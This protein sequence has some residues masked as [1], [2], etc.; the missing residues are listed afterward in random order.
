MVGIIT[1]LTAHTA[2][3]TFIIDDSIHVSA[4]VQDSGEQGI[5]VGAWQESKRLLMREVDKNA[6]IAQGQ[7][8]VTG[9]LTNGVVPNLPIG[10]VYSVKKDAISDTQEI[11]LDPVR[12][13]RQTPHRQHRAREEAAMM[14]LPDARLT[15][16]LA[17]AKGAYRATQ[18]LGRSGGTAVPGLVGERVDPRLIG[19]L[20]ARL[21]EGA[22]VVAGTNGKT[23][24]ARMLTAILAAAGK[25]VLNNGAGSNLSRGIAA[26]FARDA[27]AARRDPTAEIA[28]IETDEAAFPGIVAALRPRLIVL[29]NLFRDQLDRYGELNSIATKWESGAR[30]ARRRARR[31]ST[32]PTTRHSA[33]SPARRA[34]GTTLV[35]FGLGAHDY[36]LAGVDAR[37][38]RGALPQCGSPLAYHTLSVGHLGDWYC[39]TGDN[40]RPPLAF[41]R[42]SRSVCS[43]IDGA[44]LVVRDD[45]GE[46]F[47]VEVQLPGLYNVYNVARRERRRTDTWR[48]GGD[49]PRDLARFRRALRP[50]RARRPAR[51]A[52]DAGAHQEPDGRE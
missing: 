32:T 15:A 18:L 51:S 1:D 10:Y 2:L 46:T 41:M 16:A 36:T 28:V 42:A 19:K 13:L 33:R 30:G 4:V 8:I 25:R 5:A 38:G 17:A 11:E 9:N 22:V 37:G 45:R 14:R 48:P 20:A 3:V 34:P 49:D 26:S 39:P 50:D 7:R 35:P 52:A 43:G 6:K 31:S 23:T 40:A 21:P 47:A 29:N 27:S 12:E 44:S 24:T